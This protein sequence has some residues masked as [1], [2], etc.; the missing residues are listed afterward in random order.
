MTTDFNHGGQMIEYIQD[1]LYLASYDSAPSSRTPFP[2]HLDAPKSPSKRARAQPATPSKRRSPVY[3]TIDDTLLYNAFHADFGPLHIGHLYRFAVLFH[4]ILGDPANS[5]RPVVFYSKTDAR[6]R[7][8]AAC[9]VAC[10]MVMIQSWPP[11]LALAP[12]AQADPPYMPFRD[13]GY[14]QADFILNI[15]DVVYG[16]WKAKEQSLCGL[17]DFNLEEYEKF[18]R[19]D[20]GDFNW[21]TPDF[22]AFASPQHQPVEPIP[23]NTPEYNALPT[24]IS[25]ISSSKLP[26]PFKNVL[27]HFHQRNVGLVVRL[28]SELYCPSYF[29]A[30]GIAH[31]DMIFE[32]GTC[33]PLQLV[34]RFIKMAHEMITIKKKGIAVHCKAGLG[35]T[36]CLIGAY[37][38]YKYGFTANEVIAFMRFMR[39]GMVVGPQQHWLHLNQGAFREWWFEDSMREKLAQS[40]PVTPRVSTKKRT[41]NGVVSTPP[42]NSHSK[43]AALGEIDH[44]EAAAYP[45]QDLPAPTPGQ[46]RKS[47]RKD[48][49]HHPYS[50]TA[51]GSL[52]VE[53]EQRSHRSH[54]KSNESSESEEEI[55]LRR[56]AQRSSRSPVASPTSRSI[57]YS[58]TVTASYTLT[59]DNHKDQENWVDHSAPKTPVSRKSGAAPISV[60]KVRSSPRR[61]TENTRSESRGVRKPSGR[62]GSNT[63]SPARAIKTIH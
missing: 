50:R 3:F 33:P 10:Y 45:D 32:D 60:S 54:R 57:S 22:L 35:R 58:A 47:H 27:A 9:L 48:S 31:I 52:A 40:T 2:F 62:I 15:Q 24:T 29:T 4:E 63:I 5:D 61:P 7:A 55:Q 43:R 28:N 13:A 1:R 11:H 37:L 34:R 16:V 39:P 19:V 59:E 53:N 56:L 26:M 36:G 30:M 12:I 49:R 25:E 46:P 42:N 14:S 51:S 44:N 20:M 41:S 17:R 23:V 38:I 8:N 6:S 21:V 18:E